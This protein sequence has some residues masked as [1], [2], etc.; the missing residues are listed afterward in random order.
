MNERVSFCLL[1]V[2]VQQSSRQALGARWF[3][4]AGHPDSNLDPQ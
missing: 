2:T 4:A 1:K 3:E